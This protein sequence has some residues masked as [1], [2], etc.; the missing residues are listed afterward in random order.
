[1]NIQ[2]KMN[3]S[4]LFKELYELYLEN[5]KSQKTWNTIIKRTT[6]FRR[7]L[8][9][10]S[11]L[12]WQYQEEADTDME[13]MIYNAFESYDPSRGACVY[14]WVYRLCKQA[15]WKTIN[16]HSNELIEYQEDISDIERNA[17][18][19]PDFEN[20]DETE[21]D[22]TQLAEDILKSVIKDPLAFELLS[23]KRGLFTN[24]KMKEREIVE[25]DIFDEKTV[26][27]LNGRATRALF[28]LRKYVKETGTT[29]ESFNIDE[30]LEWEKNNK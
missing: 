4:Q 11:K 21:I 27:F 7:K 23:K 2:D 3:Y 14:T 25:S 17:S 29:I 19:E 5:P 9:N 6:E 30:Y 1:M 16:S 24:D 8:I 28:K 13:I 18:S 20:F 26:K 10:S 15:I 22:Y 12:F